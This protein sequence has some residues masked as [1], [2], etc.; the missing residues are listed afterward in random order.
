L[1]LNGYGFVDTIRKRD[2][3]GSFSWEQEVVAMLIQVMIEM[4]GENKLLSFRIWPVSISFLDV[5]AK[6][7]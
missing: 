3:N 5:E 2:R 1:A 7:A 4:F 6:D